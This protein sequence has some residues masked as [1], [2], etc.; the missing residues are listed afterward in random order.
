MTSGSVGKN[1][2]QLIKGTLP[3]SGRPETSAMSAQLPGEGFL[4]KCHRHFSPWPLQA[5]FEFATQT[6]KKAPHVWD[7]FR[8]A[9]DGTLTR[10]LIL[11]KDAL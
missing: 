8:G 6:T 7:S 11:G 2:G 4:A 10:G 3:T 1:R 9:G 5:R